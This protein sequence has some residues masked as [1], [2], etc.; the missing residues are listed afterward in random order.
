VLLY[1]DGMDAAS[2]DQHPVGVASLLA[3]A[4]RHRD[5]PIQE[6]VDRLCIDL[7]SQTRQTD[8]LTVLG[9]ERLA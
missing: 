1:T 3:C 6:L 7:F 2:C 9:I 5:L 8:D 4:A